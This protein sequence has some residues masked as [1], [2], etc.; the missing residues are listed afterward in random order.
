MTNHIDIVH[1]NEERPVS[2]HSLEHQQSFEHCL[3]NLK[4]IKQLQATLIKIATSRTSK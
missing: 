4:S 3:F 2:A 1:K